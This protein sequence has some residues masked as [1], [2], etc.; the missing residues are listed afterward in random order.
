MIGSQLIG[1]CNVGSNK[2]HVEPI[3]FVVVSGA[4][5]RL[6]DATLSIEQTLQA[7]AIAK[8]GVVDIEGTAVYK[9][10][11]PVVIAIEDRIR[12]VGTVDETE[13]SVPGRGPERHWLL[14]AT[15]LNQL[16]DRFLVAD[17]FDT[18]GQTTGD[19]VRLLVQ[20]FL[21]PEG[22]SLDGI[23]DGVPITTARWQF[24]RL[25][26]VFDELARETG[27]AWTITSGR[28]FRFFPRTD[29]VSS[30]TLT[31]SSRAF[32]EL[33]SL[34]SREG[35]RNRQYLIGAND[36]QSSPQSEEFRGDGNQRTFTVAR[37][38]AEIAAITVD[39]V[40]QSFGVLNVDPF[41]QWYF[42]RGEKTVTQDEEEMQ[43]QTNQVLAISYR[44]LI[45]IVTRKDSIDEQTTMASIEGGTGVY[46]EAEEDDR[47]DNLPL[48]EA[49]LEAILER[50]G[51][52]TDRIRYQ[53]DR[54]MV[55]AGMTQSVD[56]PTWGV[57]GDYLIES[58]SVRD[59]GGYN[60][61][62][63]IDAIGGPQI[64][65][66]N[67][68]YRR[69]ITTGRTF[70]IRPDEVVRSLDVFDS[71]VIL[72]DLLTIRDGISVSPPGS[73]PY[74]VWIF[75]TAIVGI[76]LIGSPTYAEPLS[77]GEGELIFRSPRSRRATYN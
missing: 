69:L 18:V 9:P 68:F 21:V 37:P 19:I 64:G 63:S 70:A 76:S 50:N 7:R 20:R 42:R 32:I 71:K 11:Q 60:L 36:T 30:W 6:K 28:V 27:F 57:S 56:L 10:G 22:I 43:L 41:R 75:G 3:D 61:R 73:D 72:G 47:I 8:I 35:Y 34:R 4:K 49:R 24:V 26:S 40:D 16:A 62:T 5:I 2:L 48:A 14:T 15:D 46:E 54:E 23:N 66:L 59:I 77:D 51:K 1:G 17:A 12:F 39:G 38:V 13:C 58:V 74:T 55:E 44:G 67:D 45:P 65:L 31:E 33:V 53:S 25:S 52:L 29:F